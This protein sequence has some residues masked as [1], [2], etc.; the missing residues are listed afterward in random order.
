MPLLSAALD[1][2]TVR[3]ALAVHEELVHVTVELLHVTPG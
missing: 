2:H 1:A 3:R